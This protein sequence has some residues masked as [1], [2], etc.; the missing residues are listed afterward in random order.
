MTRWLVKFSLIALL[1]ATPLQAQEVV[2]E[3]DAPAKGAPEDTANYYLGVKRDGLEPFWKA[4]VSMAKH[5]RE[6][7]NNYR[8]VR[9]NK[10]AQLLEKMIHSASKACENEMRA[11]YFDSMREFYLNEPFPETFKVKIFP[12]QADRRWELKRRMEF[13]VAPTHI[14]YIEY[15]DGEYTEGLQRYI[16][17]ETY[18]EPRFF[19]LM[20]CPSEKAMKE[21]IADAEQRLAE[22]EAKTAAN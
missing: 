18:P 3:N 12:V 10:N 9:L 19:E 2:I 22:E 1:A 11:P 8:D 21:M 15:K 4:S 16:R 6:F 13:P 20:K 17:E 7:V 14:L 5:E